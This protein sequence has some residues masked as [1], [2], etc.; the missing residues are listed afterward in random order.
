MGGKIRKFFF[1]HRNPRQIVA[2]N[3]LWLTAGEFS[4]RLI[5]AFVM[6][7]AARILG[8]HGYGVFSYILDLAGFFTIFSSVGISFMLTRD[9]SQQPEKRYEF[10]ATTFFIRIVLLVLSLLLLLV[11]APLF[12][13]VEGVRPLFVFAALLVAFDGFRDLSSA[14]FRAFER[15][16]FEALTSGV[17]NITIACVALL[18]IVFVPTPYALTISYVSGAG[19]GALLGIFLLRNWFRKIFTH[20]RK[21]LVLPILKTASAIL[22]ASFFGPFMLQIDTIMLGWW[23]GVAEVG[24][25]AA[26]QRIIF[27]LLVLPDILSLTIFPMLSR[28][29]KEGNAARLQALVERA[30]SVLFAIALPLLL[31]GVILASP[32]LLFLYGEEYVSSALTLQI[33]LLTLFWLFPRGVVYNIVLAHDRRF[34]MASSAALGAVTNVILNV[35]LIPRYGGAG[36]AIATF[37]AVCVNR[38]LIFRE[39]RRLQKFSTFRLLPKVIIASLAGPGLMSYIL[40]LFHVHVLLIILLSALFYFLILILLRAPIV[41]EFR[42]FFRQAT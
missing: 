23:K 35:I 31:G 33:L 18:A 14:V 22:L 42:A 7:Y 28:L 34:V 17:T 5:R 13:R 10:F 3:F 11:A 15:M 41:E 21:E 4:S 38:G 20:F 29:V 16:E 37:C 19:V 1:E 30:F 39:A 25:Y 9:M 26:A 6:I 32:L 8:A 36:S 12:S 27:L 24:R 2:K 40:L